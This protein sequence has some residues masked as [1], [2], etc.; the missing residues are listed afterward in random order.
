MKLNLTRNFPPLIIASVIF[1]G[2]SGCSTNAP[3]NPSDNYT[4]AQQEIKIG[5]SSS[6]YTAMKI[7]ADAYSSKV[8]N[9]KVTFLPPSQS[10]VAIAGVKDGLID[11]GSISKQL[12]PEEA[13]DA[14]Q[15]HQVAK[16]ALVL[17]TNPSVKNIKNLTTENLQAIYSGKAKN[18]QEFGGIDAK[19]VVLDRPEDESAKKLLR[20]H[21][22]G[23]DLKNSPS[24]VVLRKESDLIAAIESTPNSIGVFS[25]AYAISKKL[26]VNRLSINGIEPT[27]ENIKSEKY[28]MV[29]DIG[30]VSKKAPKSHVQ[31]LL[32]FASTSDGTALLNQSGFVVVNQ[33]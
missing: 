17:A 14:L 32:D 5:G 26:P 1:V 10:E 24:S 4:E 3:S 20:K 30:M 9:T 28:K 16:D 23:K 27:S 15:Y 29:R 25:L 2:L 8:K 11:L 19:I 33:K 18:W 13:G 12:K 6:T 21:Y 22:L 7:L 31:A